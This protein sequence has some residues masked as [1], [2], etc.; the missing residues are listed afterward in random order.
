MLVLL[1]SLIN[2]TGHTSNKIALI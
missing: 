1:T 2:L